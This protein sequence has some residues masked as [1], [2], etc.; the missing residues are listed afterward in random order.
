MTVPPAGVRRSASPRHRAD[1]PFAKLTAR[2]VAPPPKNRPPSGYVIMRGLPHRRIARIPLLSERVFDTIVIAWTPNARECR[3]KFRQVSRDRRC[4]RADLWFS[5]VYGKPAVLPTA[6]G[7]GN[8]RKRAAKSQRAA[9]A[10]GVG[11]FAKWRGYIQLGAERCRRG[12]LWTWASRAPLVRAA[13]VRGPWATSP[14]LNVRS[15][16]AVGHSLNSTTAAPAI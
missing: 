5:G 15:I 10:R 11:H 13:R 7:H 2:L 14:A 4:S 1:H 12:T 8:G 3:W 6:T 16:E 9:A